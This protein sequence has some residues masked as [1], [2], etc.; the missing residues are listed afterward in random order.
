VAVTDALGVTKTITPTFLTYPH[1]SLQNGSCLNPVGAS[2]NTML[3]YSGGIPGALPTAKV[4]KNPVSYGYPAVITITVQSGRLLI[5]V[6]PQP[7]ALPYS[8][9]LTLVVTD[10]SPCGSGVHC[11]SVGASLTVTLGG[12]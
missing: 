9:T 3:F 12:G 6:G 7:S 10:Q 4:T 2:C 11:S 8:G 1:I 5:T